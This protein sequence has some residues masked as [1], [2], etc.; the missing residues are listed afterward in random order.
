[1]KIQT[2]SLDWETQSSEDGNSPQTAYRINTA[3]TKIRESFFFFL[4][5]LD[6]I[7]F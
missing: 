2:M 4:V 1:M 7:I 3:P 6:K 5:D